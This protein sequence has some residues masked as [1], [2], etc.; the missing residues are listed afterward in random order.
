MY[1]QHIPGEYFHINMYVLEQMI[2]GQLVVGLMAEKG[3]KCGMPCQV[4]S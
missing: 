3:R 4:D 1:I 2:V